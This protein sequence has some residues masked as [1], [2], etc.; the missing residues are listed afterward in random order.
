M[1][2]DMRSSESWRLF[3]TV[4]VS[5]IA[6]SVV[7]FGAL[8]LLDRTRSRT[9]YAEVPMAAGGMEDVISVASERL[10]DMADDKLVL[11]RSK[12]Q[13][14]PPKNEEALKRLNAWVDKGTKR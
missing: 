4:A 6:A 14:K 3:L 10:S 7:T 5:A 9:R 8:D 13:N 12:N 11:V 2:M 1:R